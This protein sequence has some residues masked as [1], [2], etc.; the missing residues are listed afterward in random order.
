MKI[1]KKAAIVVACL[2]GLYYFS[3]GALYLAGFRVYRFP[4]AAMEP[5]IQKNEMAIGRLPDSYRDKISRFDIAVCR[6]RLEAS[7]E[8]Y[9]KRVIGLP[10]ER[11]TIN[12]QGVKIDGRVLALPAAMNRNGL[13]IKPCELT[14]PNDAV[15]V[16]GDNTPNSADRRYLGPILK[17]DVVGYL[18]FK[19]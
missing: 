15:F 19:K 4:T 11:I 13:K 12:A 18:V 3:F 16:L 10:G 14:I 7:E 17:K 6:V 1:L 8:L 2:V 5:T 9:G